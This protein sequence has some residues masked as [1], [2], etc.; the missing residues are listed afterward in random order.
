MANDLVTPDWTPISD[1]EAR[2]VLAAYVEDADLAARARTTWISPRPMSAAALVAIEDRTL[3]VKRHHVRVRSAARLQLE[4][5]FAGHLRSRGVVTPA[6]LTSKDGSSVLARGDFVYEVHEVAAGVDLYRDVPSWH[7]FRHRDH[8]EAAGAALARFH[9]AAADFDVGPWDFDVLLDS[10]MIALAADPPAAYRRLVTTRPGL[11]LALARYDVRDDF[12][13]VLRAPI[14]SAAARVRAIA[15]QWTHGDWHPSNLTWRDASAHATVV[16]VLDLGL[17]NRTFAL[18][19]LAVAIERSTID[20]LDTAGL[21]STSVD[22]DALDALL[23][24]YTTVTPLSDDDLVTLSATLPVAH[25]E[26]ALSEVEYFGAVVESR[27]NLDLAYRGYLLGH[28]QWFDSPDGSTLLAHLRDGD[29]R[30]PSPR[31]D[32]GRRRPRSGGG[33]SSTH[34]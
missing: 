30:A 26:F 34:Q 20:W 12:E 19:D 10:A 4:H 31:A 17:A 28:V 23:V 24:G 7:R 5:D 25:V 22:Y 15:T 16:S 14:E 8:A 21:G 27:A 33:F 11:A 13:S 29:D 6:I 3:F 32:L 1:A 18:H 2:D 9:A